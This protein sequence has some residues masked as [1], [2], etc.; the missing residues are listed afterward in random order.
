MNHLKIFQTPSQESSDT[1]PRHDD[2]IKCLARSGRLYFS[3]DQSEILSNGSLFIQEMGWVARG[4]YECLG[5]IHINC[6]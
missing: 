1:C 3:P 4:Q 2:M 5:M 6:H